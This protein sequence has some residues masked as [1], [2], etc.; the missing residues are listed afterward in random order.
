MDAPAAT[1]SLGAQAPSGEAGIPAAQECAGEPCCGDPPRPCGAWLAEQRARNGAIVV[2][3]APTAECT[4]FLDGQE[5]PEG[6]TFRAFRFVAPGRHTI[7]C[8]STAGVISGRTVDVE[9]G[10]DTPVY[11]GP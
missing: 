6:R 1:S 4:V 10:Q 2:M 7:E 8:R 5:W 9:P 11:W 3:Q